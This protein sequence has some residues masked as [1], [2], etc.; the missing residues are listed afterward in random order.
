MPPNGQL[1]WPDVRCTQMCPVCAHMAE[2]NDD[3]EYYIL[4][5]TL[6]Q[7]YVSGNNLNICSRMVNRLTCKTCMAL[8]LKDAV[9]IQNEDDE[10]SLPMMQVLDNHLPVITLLDHETNPMCRDLPDSINAWDLY[11][12]WETSGAWQALDEERKS[13]FSQYGK[14]KPDRNHIRGQERLKWKLRS[15]AAC[16]KMLTQD[17][18]KKCARCRTAIYCSVACQ[19]SH[20]KYHR[21][22]GCVGKQAEKSRMLCNQQVQMRDHNKRRT[23]RL[24]PFVTF[25]RASPC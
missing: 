12:K 13:A 6:W 8:L 7:T 21:K 24:G 2:P 20:W 18:V 5:E 17:Q 19:H 1:D 4:V 22:N 10:S 11:M 3:Q 25:S 9:M 23:I 15:C 14:W 16:N